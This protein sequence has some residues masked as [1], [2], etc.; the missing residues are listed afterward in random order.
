[1]TSDTI[2]IYDGEMTM[3]TGSTIIDNVEIFN[4]SQIDTEKSALR[5]ESAA[6]NYSAVTNS[7]LHNGYAW[8]INVKASKNIHIE[9]NVIF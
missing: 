3:R 2:E 5:W 8:G 1:M 9:N 7:A 6:S 4:C